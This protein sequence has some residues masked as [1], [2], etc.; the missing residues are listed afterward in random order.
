MQPGTTKF[1][2]SSPEN[3]ETGGI[4]PTLSTGPFA[5]RTKT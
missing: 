2:L 5:I 1:D 4:G 3:G